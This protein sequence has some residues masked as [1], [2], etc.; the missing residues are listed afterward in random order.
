MTQRLLRMVQAAAACCAPTLW[1]KA[2]S[3]I[4][5]KITG[6]KRGWVRIT[7]SYDANVV[8]SFLL[9]PTCGRSTSS[10][11]QAG[12]NRTHADLGYLAENALP[13]PCLSHRA[14]G[15][16]VGRRNRAEANSG[17]CVT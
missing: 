4:V 12:G 17:L 1:A 5:T 10:Q 13:M 7:V 15:S 16:A 3:V 8:P 11:L 14:A 2:A 6:L 9:T